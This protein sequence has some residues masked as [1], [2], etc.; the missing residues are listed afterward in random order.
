MEAKVG[1]N[2]LWLK[3]KAS[4]GSSFRGLGRHEQEVAGDVERARVDVRRDEH[5]G[6][7]GLV[8]AAVAAARVP[9][10]EPHP[11]ARARRRDRVELLPLAAEPGVA[12]AR[13]RGVARRER[14]AQAR[15]PA[16]GREHLERRCGALVRKAQRA[17]L[18][19]LHGRVRADQ[20][21]AHKERK[22]H[23]DGRALAPLPKAR[24]H[25]VCACGVISSAEF[26][27]CME[28]ANVSF[29][30]R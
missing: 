6:D 10:L 7:S 21:P 12:R 3:S 9:R 14:G 22:R 15:Q 4:V 23:R 2:K 17:Q 18:L 29:L 20:A 28:T 27:L 5:G 1:G 25:S 30:R 13:T 8:R 16:D 19:A 26:V 24:K 11:R